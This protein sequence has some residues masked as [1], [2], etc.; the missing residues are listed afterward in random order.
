MLL[1]K[2]SQEFRKNFLI[3]YLKEVLKY[4]KNFETVQIEETTLRRIQE[5]KQIIN[6]QKPPIRITN[7]ISQR[8]QI[9]SP[10]LPS[11]VN[12]LQPTPTDREIN[13]KKLNILIKDPRVRTIECNGPDQEII[14]SGYFGTKITKINLSNEEINETLET[15][16]QATKIPV[17]Q[18]I[19]KIIY[20][21]LSLSAIIS[22]VIKTKF[23]IEKL[24]E[25]SNL[26]SPRRERI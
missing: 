8:V 5:K 15:F 9:P 18:G 4:S 3:I 13:L 10:Q 14:V 7:P 12:Y 17:Q 11:T 16:S 19:Y 21:R 24:R 1:Q 23:V 26:N 22:K 25:R 2:T 6:F 20:G